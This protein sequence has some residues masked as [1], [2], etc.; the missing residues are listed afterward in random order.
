MA[1][2]QGKPFQ[3]TKIWK[4]T[5]PKLQLLGEKTGQSQAY[6]VER[7]VQAELDK[8]RGEAEPV[9]GMSNRGYTK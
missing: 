6:I 9:R 2:R 3:S 8:V 5:I 4:E 1:K 7:L